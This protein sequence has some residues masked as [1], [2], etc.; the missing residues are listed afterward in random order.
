[1][2]IAQ[3]T[4]THIK[5]PGKLAYGRVDTAS[6]LRVAIA[7][8]NALD[9]APDLVVLTGDLVDMGG[10]EEY[11]L[12]TSILKPLRIPLVVIPG[13]HDERDAMRAAFPDHSY[14]P[15]SG[16]LHYV[17]EDEYPLRI[18]GL[19]TVVPGEGG[20]EF[21]VERQEW[22]STELAKRPET[23]TLILMHHPPFTT[24]IA[25]MD[26][27]GLKGADQFERIL[28]QHPQVEAVL[29]G[30]LHRNIQTS[31]GGRRVLTSVSTAHQVVLDLRPD[32]PSHFCMEP[33]GFMQHLWA[34]GRLVSH[35]TVIGDFDG[36]YPFYEPDG[37][38]ID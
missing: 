15:A 13:N 31:V 19:D 28:A 9:P 22:L 29:C 3:I 4:D 17:I 8:L 30:H 26:K 7:R 27:V 36:P 34:D 5:A 20:G 11:E 33:P 18:I 6:M 25:H 24:G 14:L 23:P 16:F 35:A 32:G 1:M 37:R 2:L 10:A 12:L 38:L 21:C